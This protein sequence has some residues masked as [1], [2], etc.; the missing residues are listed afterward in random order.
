MA[1]GG[2]GYVAPDG[3]DDML[4]GSQNGSAAVPAA[5]P[6]D[7]MPLPGDSSAGAAA[8]GAADPMAGMAAMDGMAG[9]SSKLA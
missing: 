1:G 5:M 3:G 6:A 4:G 8:G 9:M 7:S 2:D